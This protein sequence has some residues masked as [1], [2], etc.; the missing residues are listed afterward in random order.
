MTTTENENVNWQL[1]GT[2]LIHADDSLRGLEVGPS[3]SVTS[4]KLIIV[5][6]C[7][8]ISHMSEQRF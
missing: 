2:D 5:I 4:S 3:I 6:H 1:K 7:K 8:K